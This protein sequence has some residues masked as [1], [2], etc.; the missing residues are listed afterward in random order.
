MQLPQFS[1]KYKN[2]LQVKNRCIVAM[3]KKEYLR[4]FR[5]STFQHFLITTTQTNK[6]STVLNL[7]FKNEQKKVL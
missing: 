4:L 5:P 3:T 6:H 1:K 7:I 2:K